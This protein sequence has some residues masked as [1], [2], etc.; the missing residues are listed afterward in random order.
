MSYV[1]VKFY[2]NAH[3]GRHSITDVLLFDDGEMERIHDYVQWVFPN[4]RISQAQRDAAPYPLS[5]DEAIIMAS[6]PIIMTKVYIMLAKILKHWGIR[7]R[8]WATDAS[9]RVEMRIVDPQRFGQLL[10]AGNHNQLR[11]TRVLT[12]LFCIG[13]NRLAQTLRD[14]VLNPQ[15]NLM[16][17]RAALSFWSQLNP[18]TAWSI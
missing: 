16:P 3:V 13:E 2:H 10:G 6:D 12:F 9:P 5:R 14:L 18:T 17:G 15:S 11:M 1:Y 4:P 7:W 8:P